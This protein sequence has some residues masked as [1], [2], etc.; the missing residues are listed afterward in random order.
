MLALKHMRSWSFDE[1]EREV[2]AN[3]VYRVF[4]R[5]GAELGSVGS[6]FFALI[7]GEIAGAIKEGLVS[8]REVRE[9]C[10]KKVSEMKCSPGGVVYDFE[11]ALH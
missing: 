1:L 8:F 9:P 3:L 4:T 2:R 10:W 7:T 5:V 11:K 6:I